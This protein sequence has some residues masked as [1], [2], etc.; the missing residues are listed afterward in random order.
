MKLAD[1]AR[2]SGLR[3]IDTLVQAVR[4][5]LSIRISLHCS[6]TV[7]P[8]LEPSIT[9]ILVGTVEHGRSTLFTTQSILG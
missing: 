5:I 3:S 6:R 8:I 7:E 1:E 2:V 4:P 9:R